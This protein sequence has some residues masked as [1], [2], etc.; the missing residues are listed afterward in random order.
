MKSSKKFTLSKKEKL[1]SQIK[2]WKKRRTQRMRRKQFKMCKDRQCIKRG[3]SSLKKEQRET[4]CKAIKSFPCK[5]HAQ[6][7]LGA[8]EYQMSRKQITKEVLLKRKRKTKALCKYHRASSFHKVRR[9]GRSVG[10]N[11]G[12]A[13]LAFVGMLLAAGPGS[14][15]WRGGGL[16]KRPPTVRYRAPFDRIPDRQLAYTLQERGKGEPSS[17][18]GPWRP[19][20]SADPEPESEEEDM[21]E[22]E[23]VPEPE[24]E[25][26]GSTC[27][28]A[29]GAGMPGGSAPGAG[30]SGALQRQRQR[31][32][33]GSSGGGGGGGRP[34]G[35]G[36]QD[37][38][39]KKF[40]RKLEECKT[41]I[42]M[43]RPS[44]CSS[45]PEGQCFCKE[46]EDGQTPALRDAWQ[47]AMEED[48]TIVC[49]PPETPSQ[50]EAGP[51]CQPL[52][53]TRVSHIL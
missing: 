35:G 20:R 26:G 37:E 47:E 15:D 9:K 44:W 51:S 4:R 1:I 25:P 45:C 40:C 31:H 23:P 38:E 52:D 49:F 6:R 10:S 53:T 2:C 42:C 41:G 16:F 28:G 24:P 36:L 5:P 8:H 27:S 12:E 19:W 22:D 29:P 3:R 7:K 17:G 21:D 46:P 13:W 30:A 18:G 33:A 32:C 43:C 48:S 34:T 39:T 14:I 11:A 50:S